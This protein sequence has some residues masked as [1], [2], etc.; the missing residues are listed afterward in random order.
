MKSSTAALSL[1]LAL[2]LS[3]SACGGT[4]E[5]S[6]TSSDGRQL[7]TVTMGVSTIAD[8]APLHLGD[9]K[10]FF[11]DEGIELDLQPQQ[12]GSVTITGVVSGHL[13]MGF[14]NTVSLLLAHEKGLPLPAV[15]PA[16][17]VGTDAETEDFTAL[18]V[19]SDSPIN[20]VKDLAGQT[21]AVNTVKSMVDT[22]VRASLDASG[23][24]SSSVKFIE[25]PFADQVAA[26]QNKQVDVIA[27]Q[28]PF[29]TEAE[30]G[31]LKS[32]LKGY[33]VTAIP[34][35]T[36]GM[37]FT[38]EQF[39]KKSPKTVEAF[40]RAMQKSIEYAN[41]HE[42]EVREIIPEFTGVEPSVAGEIALPQWKPKINRDSLEKLS[43]KLLEYGLVKERPDVQKI[44]S[45]AE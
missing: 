30:R 40:Q 29:L 9:R 5:A 12:G 18:M 26:L 44:T 24:D 19:R 8:L 10:G 14:A 13:D 32:V 4:P 23:V 2:A 38:S 28:E 33:Y 16:A 35:F 25:I 41:A 22:M 43:D 42:S 39:L 21:I 31:G 1:S 11:R 6:P 20:S 45:H 15:A 36:N 17:S 7:E 37:Y 3:V 27:P 34:D